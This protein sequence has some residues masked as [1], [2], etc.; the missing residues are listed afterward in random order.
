MKYLAILA[1]SSIFLITLF[2]SKSEIIPKINYQAPF[3]RTKEG[4]L[5]ITKITEIYATNF[6]YDLRNLLHYYIRLNPN[7]PK[8]NLKIRKFAKRI[9]KNHHHN[10]Y[11]DDA[12]FEAL[13]YINSFKDKF[14]VYKIEKYEDKIYCGVA[15]CYVISTFATSYDRVYFYIHRGV[16][17]EYE[18]YDIYWA[19]MT[20]IKGF[21]YINW[22]I[23]RHY[24][25]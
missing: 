15:P 12:F 8:D 22:K 7:N 18:I 4:G 2:C 10:H 17:N 6:P 25:I 3:H 9:I 5:E 23:Y 13:E 16:E 1:L 24:W 21:E 19:G 20:D 14:F 11:R